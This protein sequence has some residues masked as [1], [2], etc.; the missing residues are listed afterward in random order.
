MELEKAEKL[1]KQVIER[2]SPYCQRIVVAGSIRRRRPFP[3][4]IDIVCIPSDAW[5]L[6]AE[7]L[8][9]CR[10]LSPT[11]GDKLMRFKVNGVQVD[12]YF[13]DGKTWAT[14]LLIRTGSADHNIKLASLAKRKGWK[15]HANGDGLFNESG[16]R[17]AGDTEESIF[18]ALGLEFILPDKREVG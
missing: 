6:R 7:V 12:L 1:A 4:D 8:N 16:Q 14:L 13:A 3:R 17:V 2:L 5:N 18:E 15:L 10:P 9:L 11:G